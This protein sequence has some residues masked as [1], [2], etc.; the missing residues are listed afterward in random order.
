MD[1]RRWMLVIVSVAVLGYGV[2]VFLV[3][4]TSAEIGLR[5]A[6]ETEIHR[7]HPEYLPPELNS[8]EIPK[9]GDIVT[10][11][12]PASIESWSN[13]VRGLMTFKTGSSFP[14][15]PSIPN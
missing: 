12:G 10:K 1:L 9:H 13:F 15:S 11:I 8:D 2:S 14:D 4:Q 5:C 7:V 6:F 3:A